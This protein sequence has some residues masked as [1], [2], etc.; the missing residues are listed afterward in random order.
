MKSVKKALLFIVL[1]LIILLILAFYFNWFDGLGLGSGFHLKQSESTSSKE[2]SSTE[3]VITI[4]V[5]KEAVYYN[6]DIAKALTIEELTQIL[7]AEDA[8]KSEYILIDKGATLGTYES[9]ET[10]LFSN[11]LKYTEKVE[12]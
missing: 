11:N 10:L 8:K 2:E 9:I 4:V 7:K 12:K 6:G 1:L 5:E 3:K